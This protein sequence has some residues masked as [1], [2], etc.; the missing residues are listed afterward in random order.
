MEVEATFENSTIYKWDA[1]R[2]REE[3][4]VVVAWM[5]ELTDR[6]LSVSSAALSLSGSFGL[7]S[8]GVVL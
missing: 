5:R 1:K 4:K 2:A 8:L 3:Q 6:S 7:S